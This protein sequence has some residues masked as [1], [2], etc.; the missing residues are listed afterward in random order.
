MCHCFSV[1]SVGRIIITGTLLARLLRWIELC[2]QMKFCGGI[3]CFPSG[4]ANV[5]GHLSLSIWSSC[6]YSIVRRLLFYWVYRAKSNSRF[7][8]WQSIEIFCQIPA[9][10]PDRWL[11]TPPVYWV[12]QWGP[13]GNCSWR[14]SGH[15]GYLISTTWIDLC[16]N[17][18]LIEQ[19]ATHWDV[20]VHAKQFP[21]YKIPFSFILIPARNGYFCMLYTFQ[22]LVN[23]QAWCVLTIILKATYVWFLLAQ[24]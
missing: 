9:R 19:D 21:L 14:M 16:L 18:T 15:C 17:V 12:T 8:R 1:F 11:D 13:F 5:F 20:Q 2:A 24:E 7:L 3:I 10:W 22:Y 6:S 23:Y 4:S